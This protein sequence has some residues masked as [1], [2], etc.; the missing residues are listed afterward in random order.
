M[1]RWLFL[2]TRSG[3]ARDVTSIQ[4]RLRRLRR[5][6]AARGL[7]QQTDAQQAALGSLQTETTE[8]AEAGVEAEFERSF[9]AASFRTPPTTPAAPCTAAPDSCLYTQAQQ[10]LPLVSGEVPRRS[11]FAVERRSPVAQSSSPVQQPLPPQIPPS[12]LQQQPPPP[13]AAP[14]SEAGDCLEQRASSLSFGLSPQTEEPP[15]RLSRK[16]PAAVGLLPSPAESCTAAEET[17]GPTNSDAPP[18]D[19]APLFTAAPSAET[20]S[21]GVCDN[22]L[23]DAANFVVPTQPALVSPPTSGAASVPGGTLAFRVFDRSGALSQQPPTGGA[24][25]LPLDASCAPVYVHPNPGSG[26]LARPPSPW[27]SAEGGVSSSSTA[28]L[29]SG[30]SKALDGVSPG[31]ARSS[32][33]ASG[34]A[35]CIGRSS[36]GPRGV[37]LSRVCAPFYGDV[38]SI[39]EALDEMPFDFFDKN[40]NCQLPAAMVGQSRGRIPGALLSTRR[41]CWCGLQRRPRG[42][43]RLSE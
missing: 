22:P 27:R 7:Q 4:K 43:E 10:Q 20:L 39:A 42:E 38:T 34:G 26:D 21:G 11:V 30:R 5:D 14:L 2:A 19:A 29:G 12:P 40:L 31:T 17:L 23:F 9:C 8:A 36:Q 35:G 24:G 33:G 18:P 32:P 15:Q 25:R 16:T 41:V 37:E 1:E 28:Q 3:L 13:A 6:A